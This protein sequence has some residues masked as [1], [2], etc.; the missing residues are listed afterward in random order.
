[1]DPQRL[2]RAGT[3]AAVSVLAVMAFILGAGCLAWAAFPVAEDA[4]RGSM[5]GLGLVG[6]TMALTLIR[7]GADVSPV[8]LHMTV[9]LFTTL[10]G[11][12]VAVAASERGLMISARLHLDG[13]LRRV[14]LPAGRGAALRGAHDHCTWGE[15][16]VGARAD[17]RVGLGDH[18]HDGPGGGCHPL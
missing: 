6:V 15:P 10:I 12:M 5:V 11:V 14:L 13:G 2:V 4:P 16:A 1:M 18:L 8:G 17:S 3:P 9:G 7:A